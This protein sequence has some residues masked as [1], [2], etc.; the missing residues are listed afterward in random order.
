MKSE[1]NWQPW[2]FHKDN[3]DFHYFY[4]Y[5][6][7]TPRVVYIFHRDTIN[8]FGFPV[9]KYVFTPVYVID[10]PVT[11]KEFEYWLYENDELK[12]IVFSRDE[13]NEW[14]KHCFSRQFSEKLRQTR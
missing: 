12:R 6:K 8:C 4:S 5:H 3:D 7:V 2:E 11:K 13:A 10:P 1:I 14:N 9:S